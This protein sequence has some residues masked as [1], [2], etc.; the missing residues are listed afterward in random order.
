MSAHY[1]VPNNDG[2]APMSIAALEQ[3]IA[4]HE[5]FAL[6]DVR[7]AGEAEKGHIAGCTFLPRRLLE[8]RIQELVP[9]WSTPIVLYDDGGDDRRAVLAWQTLKGLGYSSVT[10]L[11]DG[12][13][14]WCAAGHTLV[15]GSN[16]SSKLFG[17][18]LLSTEHVPELSAEE[19]AQWLATGGEI[20]LCDVRTPEEHAKAHVPGA[21][22]APSF[23]IGRLLGDFEKKSLPIVVHCAGRTRSIIAAQT[24]RDLGLD[25]VW[26]L[27]NGTMGWTLAG[28]DL[29]HTNPA[30]PFQPS[31]DSIDLFEERAAAL[32]EMH[33]VTA[34]DMSEVQA[35][36]KARDRGKINA[37][38]FDVRPLTNY[39]AG[40]IAGTVALPGGQA[41]QRAD[42]FVA[43]RFAPI[44]FIDDLEGRAAVTASWF[45]RM[46]YPDVR[47]MRE[48][49]KGWMAESRPLETGRRRR[50]PLGLEAA[51]KAGLLISPESARLALQN[52][53]D[54]IVLNVDH[55]RNF[56]D[57]HLEGSAWVPRGS[58]EKEIGAVVPGTSTPVLI[59]CRTGAQSCFANATLV[60]M[61]FT[62]TAVLDGGIVAWRRAGLPVASSDLNPTEVEDLVLPPYARGQAGM[63]RYLEWEERLTAQVG[64]HSKCRDP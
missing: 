34:I 48:G 11:A 26:A 3:L 41:V 25:Q 59:T 35:M 37:Y 8:F 29:T 9:L 5:P 49:I 2:D 32:A 10:T 45:Q 64:E 1:Q 61:G 57:A 52:T 54:T 14:G 50:A 24:L 15:S 7:E 43:V 39:L 44:V 51:A 36:V 62:N 27:K 20:L 19:L 23:D 63:K 47:V 55:S 4:G 58:L 28:Y 17:E 38:F 33:H 21:R 42:E 40:H 31:Q 30:E 46:G 60:E 53:P 22:L 16:V 12:V 18:Q 56:A 6:L 13:A